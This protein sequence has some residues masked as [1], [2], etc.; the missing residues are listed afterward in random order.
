MNGE[1]NISALANLEFFPYIEHG[2]IPALFASKIGVYAIFNQEKNLQFVGYSRDIYLSLKQHL[3]RQPE[4]C[5]WV[6][7]QS[8]SRPSRTV[9]EQIQNT[10]IAENG[11]LPLGNGDDQEKWT[12]PINVKP[13]MTPDEQEQYENSTNDELAQIKIIKSVARRVEAE[14]LSILQNRGLEEQLRFN[15]KLKEAG[16]L[17]LK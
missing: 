7:F 6:K 16:L 10:W 11:M 14:I 17:D 1:V 3:V 9:L 5:Y 4:Q 12:Q 15:P 2:Q 13:F 8:I